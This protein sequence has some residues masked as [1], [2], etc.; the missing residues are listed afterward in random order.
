[1][2]VITQFRPA[3][4]KAR[5]V[6]RRLPKNTIPP[7]TTG[8]PM[9]CSRIVEIARRPNVLPR[10]EGANKPDCVSKSLITADQKPISTEINNKPKNLRKIVAQMAKKIVFTN[11]EACL[12]VCHDKKSCEN[13]VEVDLMSRGSSYLSSVI[14]PLLASKRRR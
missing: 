14:E 2:R 3:I 4:L 12:D 1:M 6:G 13:L 8:S 10:S 7:S 9:F 11:N 5:I